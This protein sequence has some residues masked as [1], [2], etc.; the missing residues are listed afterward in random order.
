MVELGSF[1]ETKIVPLKPEDCYKEQIKESLDDSIK[2][3]LEKG[4]PNIVKLTKECLVI[5]SFSNT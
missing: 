3:V 4:L 1:F 2:L 5:K